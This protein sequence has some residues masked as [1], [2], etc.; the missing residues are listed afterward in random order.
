MMRV[1]HPA[2]QT[3]VLAL[4]LF[5]AAAPLL[6]R[7]MV[8]GRYLA[9]SGREIVLELSIG[10][11][12][13]SSLILRQYLVPGSR[14][15]SAEPAYKKYDPGSGEVLWLL[16]GLGPGTRT[17]RLRLAAPQSQPVTGEVRCLDPETGRYVTTA[18]P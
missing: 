18:I 5:G 17:V 10:A 9:D 4:L 8:S 1:V 14:I 3:L 7:G 12:A 15:V 11:P 13:P 2:G 6:A 16:S